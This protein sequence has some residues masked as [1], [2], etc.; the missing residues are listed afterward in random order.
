MTPKRKAQIQARRKRID[1]KL[2]QLLEEQEKLNDQLRAAEPKTVT[3]EETIA[4][5]PEKLQRFLAKCSEVSRQ[6]SRSEAQGYFRK[7]V[8]VAHWMLFD[9]TRR[10]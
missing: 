7:L 9:E 2:V 3:E 1:E 4:K 8:T 10:R 5:S 6:M